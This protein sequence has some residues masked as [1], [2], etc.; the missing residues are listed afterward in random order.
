[1]KSQASIAAPVGLCMGVNF[2]LGMCSLELA[3]SILGQYLLACKQGGY[4]TCWECTTHPHVY[5]VVLDTSLSG[6]NNLFLCKF[7][8]LVLSDV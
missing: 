3:A 7:A 5:I 8:V 2:G 6:A 4:P 1:M